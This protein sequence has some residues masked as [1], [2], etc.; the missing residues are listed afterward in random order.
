VASRIL[1]SC[2]PEK[3]KLLYFPTN[4]GNI[5]VFVRKDLH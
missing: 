3:Q 2:C 5:E 4:T 1:F